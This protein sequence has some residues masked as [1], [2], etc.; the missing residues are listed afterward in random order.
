LLIALYIFLGISKSNFGY[1]FPRRVT[2][3]LGIIIAAFTISISTVI[4]QALTN[5]RILT[6]SMLGFDSMYMLTQTILI[7]VLGSSSFIIVNQYANFFT[8]LAVMVLFSTF[9]YGLLFKKLGNQLISMLMIGI[10]L[11]TL[12]RSLSSFLQMVID[13]NEFSIIQDKSFASFNN[14]NT[15]ILWVALFFTLIIFV[16]ISDEFRKIDVIA[17]GKDHAVNLGI[18]YDKT[19]RK[20]LIIISFLIAIATALVGPIMFLGLLVVNMSRALSKTYKHTN[21]LIISFL[22]SLVFL[23]GGQFLLERVFNFA[24]PLS[25]VINLIGGIYMLYLLRKEMVI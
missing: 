7:F 19:M 4:F 16:Y 18:N 3:V 13:P 8:S 22:L 24:V 12:F 11:S 2:R 21:L 9:L 23:V 1:F 6:P 20:Y 5:N 14:M 15:N 17:L 25:I 10:I